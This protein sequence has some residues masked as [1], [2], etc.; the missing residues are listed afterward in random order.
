MMANRDTNPLLG[1]TDIRDVALQRLQIIAGVIA[2]D[3]GEQVF[4]AVEIEVDSSVRNACRTSNFRD[5]GIEIAALREDVGGRAQDALTLAL[6]T[7]DFRADRG[8]ALAGH[9]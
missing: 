4:L 6:G 1:A 9:R 5:F 2:E 3:A 8:G 7:R